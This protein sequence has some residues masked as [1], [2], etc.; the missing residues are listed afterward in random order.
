ML[1]E[2]A[3]RNRP[4][5]FSSF[6]RPGLMRLTVH[7]GFAKYER[8]QKLMFDSLSKAYKKAAEAINAEIVPGAMLFRL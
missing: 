2:Y 8:N 1:S 7:D 5:L 4:G 3:K 6:T